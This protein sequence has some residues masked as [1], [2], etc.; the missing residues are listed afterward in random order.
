MSKEKRWWI[1]WYHNESLGAFELH[2]PWWFSGTS[3]VCAAVIAETEEEA[4]QIAIDS[5][6]NPPANLGFRFAEER[7]DDWC[8]WVIPSGT[9]R[10]QKADWMQWPESTD[11]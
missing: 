1:S 3:T 11:D 5:Y 2:R 9:S 4:M 7:P 8:P 10:F 6:D